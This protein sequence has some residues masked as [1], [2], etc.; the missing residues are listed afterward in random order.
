MGAKICSRCGKKFDSYFKLLKHEKTCKRF[1]KNDKYFS[2]WTN[3]DTECFDRKIKESSYERKIKKIIDK[4]LID[5]NYVRELRLGKYYLDF[6]WPHLKKCV[7]V[8]GEFHDRK[9]RSDADKRKDKFLKLNGWKLYR[10]NYRELKDTKSI[11]KVIFNIKK[12]IKSDVEYGKI[13]LSE[14]SV[15]EM[16]GELKGIRY[17]D[18]IV[19]KRKRA[20]E[21]LK[22]IKK[23]HLVKRAN[24]DYSKEKWNILLQKDYGLKEAKYFVKKWMPEFYREKCYKTEIITKKG[25]EL[26]GIKL[27]RFRRLQMIYKIRHTMINYYS[28]DWK[29]KIEKIYGNK[30]GVRFM[31]NYM[32]EYCKEVGIQKKETI[33]K[34]N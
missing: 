8:D 28:Y 31:L 34:L 16:V 6:A 33:S 17:Y 27:L 7:E 1:V 32:P 18:L 20:E 23:I 29:K 3:P 30:S 10:V 15:K 25:R 19:N 22:I 24:I 4:C 13:N 14:K 9:K 5:R 21:R 26:S 12:F 11:V 2:Y